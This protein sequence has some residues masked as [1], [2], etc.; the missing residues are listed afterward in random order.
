MKSTTSQQIDGKTNSSI[1]MK[2][3]FLSHN[4]TILNATSCSEFSM[5]R[6]IL[7]IAWFREKRWSKSYLAVRKNEMQWFFW[8]YNSKQMYSWPWNDGWWSY[9][10]LR[11]FGNRQT[12]IRHCCVLKK[13][14]T[15]GGFQL[16]FNAWISFQIL[17]K[18][19]NN[20]EHSRFFFEVFAEKC[21]SVK[22]QV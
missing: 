20:E 16:G 21:K 8:W 22:L 19:W 3:I 17:S 13:N 1:K 12:T 9:F 7:N 10:S 11:M 5:Q 6:P 15:R 14:R 18:W 4:T 2:S